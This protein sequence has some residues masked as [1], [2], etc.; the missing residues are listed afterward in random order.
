MRPFFH[1]AILLCIWIVARTIE[2]KTVNEITAK[3]A[4]LEEQFESLSGQEIDFFPRNEN[5]SLF[6]VPQSKF[7]LESRPKLPKQVAAH[8]FNLASDAV[9]ADDPALAYQLLNE[10]AFFGNDNAATIVGLDSKPPLVKLATTKHPRLNWNR[11]DYYRVQ[12]AHFQIVTRDKEAGVEI[13]QRLEELYLVWSQLFF[14]CWSDK[15]RLA[16][17]ISQNKPLTPRAKKP[18]RVV[19]FS[20]RD[21]YIEFLRAKQARIE[22]TAGFYDFDSRTSYFFAGPDSAPSTQLH[23]VT[24]QLFQEVSNTAN[25]LTMNKNFWA[26]EGVA[27]YMESLFT[28]GP[29]AIVGG[30][31]AHRLQ[32]A[33]YRRLQEEFYVP[34]EELV[35]IGRDALQRDERIRRIYS[36]SAGLSHFLMDGQAGK[37]RRDFVAYLKSIYEGRDRASTLSALTSSS[38][39]ELDAQYLRHLQVTDRDLIETSVPATLRSLCLGDTAITDKGLQAIPAQRRLDWL[40][41]ARIPASDAGLSCLRGTTSLRQV[42]LDGTHI[43]DKSVQLLAQNTGLQELDLSNTAIT[44]VGVDALAGLKSLKVLWLTNTAITDEAVRTLADTPSLEFLGI[45]QNQLST[46]VI[47][48]LKKRRPNLTIE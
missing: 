41:L 11:R 34:L 22:I 27:M 16:S 8:F 31:H 46:Q 14:D 15:S 18:L 32:F 5:Q 7:A 9:D 47:E 33:R 37:Y 25:R 17:A 20:N 12:T 35:S 1:P 48:N 3:R 36:Q 38:L 29:V 19:L 21:E 2:A 42:S 23:E 40:D 4:Q 26:I 10:S 30:F 13:A 39:E 45:D 24:H 44:D 28:R 43:T 6:F